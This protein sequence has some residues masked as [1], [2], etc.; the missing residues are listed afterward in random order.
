MAQQIATFG[1]G[2][3]WCIEAAF[4][5]I[6]GVESAISGYCGGSEQTANYKAVCSGLTEHA[7]VVQVTFD[8]TQTSFQALLTFFF[9]LHDPTQLNRQGND[10]GRQY[11]SV[12]FYHDDKQKRLAE[13]AI[14]EFELGD[15][16]FDPI[17]T[18][19]AAIQPFYP[20]EDY[21][22]HYFVGHQQEPYCALVIAP[23][24][25]KFRQRYEYALKS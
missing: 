15:V 9:S 1:G 16:F 6:K 24:L 2:C 20:A 25:S 10:V 23:K 13:Q 14:S 21:H 4:N 12:I 11:R 22:Q 19:L 17:V 7:E 18:E 8:D 3:F 5:A